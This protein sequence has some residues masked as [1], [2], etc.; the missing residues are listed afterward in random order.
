MSKLQDRKD[1]L[2]DRLKVLQEQKRRIDADAITEAY[3]KSDKSLE[4]II[5]F[6]NP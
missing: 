5:I 3:L 4:E 2:E 1:K 6:L